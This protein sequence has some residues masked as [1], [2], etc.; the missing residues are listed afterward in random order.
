VANQLP[1]LTQHSTEIRALADEILKLGTSEDRATALAIGVSV[2][3]TAAT[4]FTTSLDKAINGNTSGTLAARLGTLRQPVSAAAEQAARAGSSGDWG[5][6]QTATTAVVTAARA[7]RPVAADELERLLDARI[8]GFY[9]T[10]A[11]RLATVLAFVLM[12]SCFAYFTARSIVGPIKAM[13]VAMNA[14]ADGNSTIEVP[15]RDRGD[16]LG[17]MAHAVEIFK[18]NAIQKLAL[19]ARQDNEREIKVRRQEKTDQLVGFFDRSVSAVLRC[20]STASA[21]MAQTSSALEE[22]STVTGTHTKL[23]MAEV[24][25]TSASVQT[26]AAASQQLSASIDDIGR[27]ASDSSRI[28]S[29]A[30]AQSTKIVDKVTALRDAATEIGTVVE[31]IN[32]IAS[33][34]NL[35]A[36]NATI[37]AARAGEAGK[38]FAVVASEVKSLA[39]QTAKATDEIGAQIKS[40][41]AA[42]VEAAEAIQD[43][44]ATVGRVSENASSIAASVVEQSSA[45]QEIARSVEHV[46]VSTANVAQ[47]MERV[48]GAVGG[49]GERATEVKRTASALS[50]EATT[51]SNEVRDF[52]GAL[53]DLGDG[54]DLRAYDLNV[55]ATAIVDGRSI[56]GRVLTVSP[57]GALFAGPLSVPPS[58]IFELR[59]EGVDRSLCARFIEAGDGGFQ[60]QLPLNHE[61]LTYMSETLRRLAVA[62]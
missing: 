43:I 10:L 59:I 19:E 21:N 31:L 39:T 28:T 34:T 41:Q 30:M 22:S 23:V 52:L 9:A 42:T 2:L 13:T 38:G 55:A 60:L 29:A 44:V 54:I 25:Q 53:R 47:S 17:S 1:A 20:V 50:A 49:T 32:N 48:Q 24:E 12:G 18:Q 4:G 11:T 45:T 5:A 51:L 16:E 40:I 36:L 7:F 56:T 27:Q 6:V 14:L 57:G 15:G 37:E 58:T 8:R 46:S 35:L 62:A 61:H 33:Q 26:V 3:K